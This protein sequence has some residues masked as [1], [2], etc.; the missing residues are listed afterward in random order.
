MS[1][2]LEIDLDAIYKKALHAR[3]IANAFE[4]EDED[5]E[6]IIILIKEIKRLNKIIEE[7]ENETK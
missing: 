2:I 6:T 3:V 1:K 4:S 5:A 7:N